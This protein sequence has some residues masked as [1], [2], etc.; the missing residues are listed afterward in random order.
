MSR[1]ILPLRVPLLSLMFVL[2]ASACDFPA[3]LSC[4]R[5]L[6]WTALDSVAVAVGHSTVLKVEATS[7]G[8]KEH[9][10]VDVQWTASDASIARVSSTGMVTG[11]RRGVAYADGVDRGRWGVGPFHVRVDV[12]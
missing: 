2:M 3:G 5:E 10:K 12:R 7:C 4:T 6:G 8:G 11:V 1:S 9:L